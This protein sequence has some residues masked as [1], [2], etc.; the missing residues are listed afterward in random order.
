M[1]YKKNIF[2]NGEG[3]ETFTSEEEWEKKY[4]KLKDGWDLYLQQGNMKNAREMKERM[5]KLMTKK[6]KKQIPSMTD[7]DIDNI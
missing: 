4:K 6:P 5:D 7:A 1:F 2:G 3:G